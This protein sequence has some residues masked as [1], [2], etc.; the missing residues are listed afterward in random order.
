MSISKI[1]EAFKDV[2]KVRYEALSSSSRDE[3]LNDYDNLDLVLYNYCVKYLKI[4]LMSGQIPKLNVLNE[5][6]VEEQIKNTSPGSIEILN[7]YYVDWES[8]TSPCSMIFDLLTTDGFAAI[9]IP[10]RIFEKIKTDIE[11]EFFINGIFGYEDG[12]D[13]IEDEDYILPISCKYIGLWISRIKTEQIF[14]WTEPLYDFDEDEGS[15]D[16]K[17]LDMLHQSFSNKIKRT[18]KD[19]SYKQLIAGDPI[20]YPREKL[21]NLEHLYYTLEYD[22]LAKLEFSNI[23]EK[24]LNNISEVYGDSAF[25][26]K[27]SFLCFQENGEKLEF[28]NTKFSKFMKESEKDDWFDSIF[29]KELKAYNDNDSASQRKKLALIKDFIIIE[30]LQYAFSPISFS[31]FHPSDW[32]W[33]EYK[34]WQSMEGEL[35]VCLLKINTSEVLLDY[36]LHFLRSKNGN[37]KL[38]LASFISPKHTLGLYEK[39]YSWRDIAIPLPEIKDQKVIVSSL[40]KTSKLNEKIQTLEDSLLTNPTNAIQTEI[41]ITDMVNRLEMLSESDQ[42]SQWINKRGNETEHIEFKQT[43]RLDIK[44]QTR[45]DRI[46]TSALKTIVGFINNNGGYL[47]IGV[48]DDNQI[49]GMEDELSKFHKGSH[50]RF[51]LFFGDKISRRIDKKFFN[52]IS[53]EL[54]PISG[55]Y[56]FRVKCIKVKINVFLMGKITT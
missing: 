54:I 42:I 56:V 19:K 29:Y 12:R 20:F 43:L 13:S 30:T 34:Q 39:E 25:H 3:Y 17:A 4:P 6:I 35:E 38:K 14:V 27:S 32:T 18:P 28:D 26:C 52:N 5:K 33:N 51:K 16:M 48:S 24:I 22:S 49:T 40:N 1:Q 47:V 23:K 37:L 53:Y 7:Y 50:D 2:D 15:D 36:L 8:Y 44:T 41:E 21:I 46:E 31:I 11:P 10:N 45:E 55:M 9:R